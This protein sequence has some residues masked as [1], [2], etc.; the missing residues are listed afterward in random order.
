MWQL[1]LTGAHSPNE[2]WRIITKEWGLR[3]I[4]WKRVGG[5]PISLSSVY[6]IFSNPFY[7][8]VLE[9]EGKTYPGKHPPMITIDEFDRVQQLLGRPGRPRAKHRQFAYT[10]MIRCGECNFSVTAEEK[11][12]RHGAH[13]AYYHCTKKRLDFRCQQ[14]CVSVTDLEQ[15]IIQFL[16]AITPPKRLQEWALKRLERSEEKQR[17]LETA[18]RLSLEREQASV[19][20]ELDNLTRLRIRDLLTDEEYVKQRQELEREQI[21]VAQRLDV[22]RSADTRFEPAEMFI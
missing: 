21:R 5:K 3:T 9:W 12:N 18:Q 15:Q 19:A 17:S 14:P 20:K 11:V 4:K 16:E 7:A 13:Y 1:M 8:G 22:L 10:G 2:I 6:R